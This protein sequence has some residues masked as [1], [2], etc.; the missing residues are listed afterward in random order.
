MVNDMRQRKTASITR[1]AADILGGVV[2]WLPPL[3][4]ALQS[5]QSLSCLQLRQMA[6]A[7]SSNK[8]CS[9][10]SKVLSC[11]VHPL[12]GI[13]TRIVRLIKDFRDVRS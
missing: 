3:R 11:F 12:A 6:T 13:A 4:L 8:S 10:L 5:S 9:F 1:N 7:S 2:C